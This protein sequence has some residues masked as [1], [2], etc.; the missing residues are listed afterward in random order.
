MSTEDILWSGWLQKK[1][2]DA[3]G[4]VNRLSFMGI[5]TNR[6]RYFVLSRRTITYY[7]PPGQST[8]GSLFVQS[9]SHKALTELGFTKKGTIEVDD[10]VSMKKNDEDNSLSLLSN[11]GRTYEFIGF[12]DN[13]SSLD[14]SAFEGCLR[15][16]GIKVEV[17]LGT[18]YEVRFLASVQQNVDC[19]LN[20]VFGFH[21]RR[22]TISKVEVG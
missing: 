1:G 19:Y 6:D 22:T 3:G 10:I 2:G 7:A 12:E 5:S 16:L 18:I 17:D 4:M 14:L 21:R 8:R 13:A 20:L 9:P 15:N 11:S